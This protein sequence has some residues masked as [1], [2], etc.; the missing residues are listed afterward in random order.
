MVPAGTERLRF[1]R[2]TMG[3]VD[4]LVELDGDPEVMRFLTGG[5]ATSPAAVRDEQLP[6]LLAQ[7]ERHPGL[8]RWAA[9]DRESGDFLGWF[10]LDPSADGAE[11]ELGYRLR[12]SAWGRGLATEGSRALVRY[13]FD[14][15][16]VR[17]VWAETMAVNERSRRVMAKAGLRHVRTFHLQWDD[18]IPGTEHGEVEYEVVQER[19]AARRA[20]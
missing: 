15:V 11:A 18:P 2:L 16:G 8:G 1:R 6:R 12:R 7:Y 13:A 9:L 20:R 10:A 17:R 4:A 19:P 3:D 14:T 5:V